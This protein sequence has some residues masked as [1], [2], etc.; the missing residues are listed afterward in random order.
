MQNLV[1]KQNFDATSGDPPLVILENWKHWNACRVASG[2]AVV[3][4]QWGAALVR[5]ML[6]PVPS[7]AGLLHKTHWVGSIV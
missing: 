6:R 5:P 3:V 1:G 2:G 7:P 4:L